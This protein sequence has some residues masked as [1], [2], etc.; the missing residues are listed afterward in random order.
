MKITLISCGAKKAE[1][2]TSAKNLY[3]GALFKYSLE[4]AG[5][6]MSNKIY[7]LSAKHHLLPLNKYIDPYD[8]TLRDFDKRRRIEWGQIV[9]NAL[10]NVANFERDEFVALAGEKYLEE[11]RGNIPNLLE[12]LRGKTIGKR[13]QFLKNKLGR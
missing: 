2:R 13:L 8:M 4:Y 12:P 11:I 5:K 9:L 6:I 7:I 1:V 10:H 3:Q